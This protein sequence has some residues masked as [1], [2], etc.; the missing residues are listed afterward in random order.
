LLDCWI[1]AGK[2]GEKSELFYVLAVA[3]FI[4]TS[5]VALLLLLLI[6]AF[7]AAVND[8]V[9]VIL[10]GGGNTG[11]II[12]SSLLSKSRKVRVLGR[13]AGRLQRLVRKGGEAFTAEV[14]DAAALTKA[15]GGARAA[16]LFFAVPVAR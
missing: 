2:L 11:S 5:I 1:F 7:E 6:V 12:A 16:Y 13:D 3:R 15:F 14:S 8:A 4:V 9:Y 10:G